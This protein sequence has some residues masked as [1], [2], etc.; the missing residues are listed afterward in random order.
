MQTFGNFVQIQ[1]K[2]F[3][4]FVHFL[5]KTFSNFVQIQAKTFG[6]F[7][8]KINRLDVKYINEGIELCLKEK[9]TPD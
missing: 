2:T 9:Y 6:I 1:V 5:V 8:C 3:G 4:I 7:G